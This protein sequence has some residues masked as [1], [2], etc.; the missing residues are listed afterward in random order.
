MVELKKHGEFS[1]LWTYYLVLKVTNDEKIALLAYMIVRKH[2]GNLVEFKDETIALSEEAK[3]I[4]HKQIGVFNFEYFDLIIE[5][6]SFLGFV[7][8]LKYGLKFTKRIKK[9]KESFS[10]ED[11]ILCNYLFSILISADKGEAIFYD[12]GVNFEVLEEIKEKRTPLDK[13]RFC[14]KKYLKLV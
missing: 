13:N 1:A 2:H 6:E 14:C 10:E 11:F 8:E 12:K 9:I 3:D 4:F 7:D 5:K